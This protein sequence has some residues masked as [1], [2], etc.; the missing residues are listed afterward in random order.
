MP[1]LNFITDAA[2]EKSIQHVL[3][4]LTTAEADAEKKLHKNVVDPFSALFDA[5]VHEMT[6]TQWLV[7]EKAR[8]IQKTMQNAVGIFHQ[9]ILG[10]MPGW[11]NLG[12]GRVVDIR[13]ENK[14][15]I[16]EVKNKFNTTKGNHKTA[17]YDDMKERL[18]K[19][20]HHN[21]TGYYVE[22]ISSARKNSSKKRYDKPFTPSDNTT[23]RQR[24]SC[25][26]IRIIDGR[27]FYD[28][29]SGEKDALKRLYQVLP[30]VMVDLTGKSAAKI[31]TDSLFTELFDKAF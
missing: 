30:K 23:G 31:V 3:H 5:H 7:G 11:E 25:E 18:A 27:T 14:Q 28:L 22:I 21:F 1:Y 2:L 20:E 9:S 17:I 10:S 4:V 6:L 26:R 8:Q 12:V 15:I 16:A 29:A 13:N 19:P 24:P